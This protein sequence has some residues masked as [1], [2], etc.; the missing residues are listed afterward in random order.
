[1]SNL[2][3]V[4]WTESLYTDSG[5]FI[6]Q[7]NCSEMFSSTVEATEFIASLDKSVCDNITQS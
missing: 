5:E 4:D 7:I 2:I 6:E 3:F 1:M